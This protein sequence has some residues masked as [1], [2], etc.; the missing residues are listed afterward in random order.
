MQAT[1]FSPRARLLAALT[2]AAALP[3]CGPD[4]HEAPAPRDLPLRVMT[5]NV[6]YGGTGVDFDQVVQAVQLAAPDI[7]ALEEPYGNAGR[8]AEA[9]GWQHV[10]ARTD[11]ISRFP[12]IDPPDADGRYVWAEVAPGY[13]VAVGNV[14]LPSDPYGPYFT[15]QCPPEAIVQLERELRLPAIAPV[16]ELLEPLA[17]AGMPVF[18]LGDFNAPSHLDWTERLRGERPQLA[19][20]LEWPVSV[21]VEAAGFVDSYR[22]VYPDARARPGLTWWAARPDIELEFPASDPQDRIDLLYAAGPAQAEAS[23]IVGELGAAD[24]DIGL[25]PWPSDHRAVVSDFVVSPAP[26]PSFV[27][28]AERLVE[29]GQDVSVRFHALHGRAQRVRLVHAGAS[30]SVREVRAGSDGVL[31]L[32]SEGLT[33]GAYELVLVGSHARELARAPLWLKAPGAATTIE[34]ERAE[35]APGEPI[36]VRFADAPGN[37]WDW[38]AVYRAPAD[39]DNDEYLVWSYT[40]T[41]VEGSLV[42]DQRAQGGEHWPLEPGDYE[43]VFLLYDAYDVAARTSFRVLEGAAPELPEQPSTPAWDAA[44]AEEPA[45]AP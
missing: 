17:E 12:L 32:S 31:T 6:E 44:C 33:A 37:R 15:T 24:V 34:T 42:L 9:L 19:Y 10:S 41:A 13:V 35:Y 16:L 3:A 4:A 11:V 39:P 8:L 23:R 2:L 43:A 27:S 40:R 25:D 26:A 30:E 1:A 45:L 28:V 7:L 21:A 36:V 14:H 18:L 29:I 22:A 20:P 5:F 38:V